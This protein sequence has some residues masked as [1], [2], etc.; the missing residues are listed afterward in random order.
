SVP[1]WAKDDA[2]KTSMVAE[3]NDHGLSERQKLS[4]VG[5]ALSPI[6]SYPETYSRMNRESRNQVSEGLHQMTHPD[7]LTDLQ[8]HG[9]WDI[10]AG[11]VKAGLGAVGYVASP[12][13]AAYRSLIG[14]PVEDVTSIPREYTEF[15]AQL[16][17]P[18][19]GLRGLP[20]EPA[21]VSPKPAI[22]VKPTN[23]VAAAANRITEASG[24]PVEVPRAFASDS[25]V[26]QR[27]GQM[28]RNVPIVG[29]SIP[30]ATGRM[31]DQLS[32]ATKAVAS[33][34]GEGSGPNVAN[35]I[36][37]TL[38]TSAEA[39]TAAATDAA[40]RSDE[41]LLAAWQRDA[42]AAHQAIAAQETNSLERARRAVGDLSPQDMGA[43]LIARLRQGEREAHA[44]KERLYGIAANSD[45]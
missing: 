17:T 22:P 6:T 13:S 23:E 10:G 19:L 36:G 7:S 12:I 9:L 33:S 18:G 11:A 4:S 41:A 31:A 30:Q 15:A 14:Q 32:D 20:G 35:R 42:D 8:G 24:V 40:R 44:N 34:Y 38:Q 39:E 3:P 5:K 27:A 16:A 28:A 2:P 43:A 25:I 37:R 45:G 26:T 21:V 1:D 29:D